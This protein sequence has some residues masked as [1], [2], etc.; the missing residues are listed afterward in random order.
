MSRR[1]RAMPG[2]LVC[3]LAATSTCTPVRP[4]AATPSPLGTLESEFLRTRSLA[5]QIDV[6]RAQGKPAGGLEPW[7]RDARSRLVATLARTD[8][9][10]LVEEDRRALRVD[11]FDRTV[12]PWRENPAP[13]VGDAPS[14]TGRTAATTPPPFCQWRERDPRRPDHGV[15]R[16]GR[17]AHPVGRKGHRPAH[18]IRPAGRN[19][20]GPA[21]APLAHARSG[22]ARP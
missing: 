8:S 16:Q 22:V 17:L 4:Y 3:M 19:R 10:R 13:V 21:R 7:Y 14:R 11:P 1:G 5:D 12:H 20:S 18:G 15:L 2:L 9:T 6:A